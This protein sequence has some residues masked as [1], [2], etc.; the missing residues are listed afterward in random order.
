MLFCRRILTV[1]FTLGLLLLGSPGD[2]AKV[3]VWQQN[4]QSHFDKARFQQALVTSEGTIRLS[5]QV[6]LLADLNALNL[7]DVI[8][9]KAGNLYAATGD[10]GK[11]W[12]V[13]PDGTAKVVYTSGD[14]QILCLAQGPNGVLFAGTG[15]SG[16]IVRIASEGAQVLADGLDSYVWALVFDPESKN[17]F[18]GTGSKGR[19]YRIGDDG[20]AQVYFQ[21]KQEH[22]LCLAGDGKGTLYA[23]TDKGGL[24]YRI[25]PPAAPDQKKGTGF[26]LYHTHQNEVRSLL[27]TDKAIYAGTSTPTRRPG[28]N[29]KTTTTMLPLGDG[30][31]ASDAPSLLA[32]GAPAPSTPPVGDNSIYRIALDGTAREIFHD[33]VMILRLLQDKGK[34]LAATGMNGQL[35]E[36]DENTREKSEIARLD[37][38]QIHCLL[39]RPDGSI[40]LGTGD[41][42]KLYVL[43]NHFAATGTVTSEVLDAKIIS[44]WGALNWR[45]TTPPETSA[46]VA[47]RS[48]NVSEAD[49]TWSAWS[50]EQTNPQ[51]ARALAPLARYIQYRVT[52]NSKQPQTTPEFRQFVLRYK[53][54]NQAPEI[55]SL[56]VP[57]LESGTV[58]NPRKLKIRWT[59]TDPNEDELTYRLS[60][61]KEGWKDWVLLE[62]DFEKKEFEWDT[63]TVPSGSYRFKVVASDRR[64]NSPEETLTA[65][66]TSASFPVAHAAPSV[67]IRVTGFDGGKAVIE[68]VATDPLVRLTE[69][70]FA[71][72]GKHWANIFPADGLFDSKSETFRFKTEELRPGS[73]VLMLRVKN[74]A[75]NVGSGDVLF[76]VPERK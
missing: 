42:G 49:D 44:K 19:I 21:T 62:D 74:A 8:A 28:L 53:T 57:D 23:G 31:L 3:K 43:E 47:V 2:A 6:K 30:D 7:W 45:A 58:D 9:D 75:G 13:A 65:E 60:F 25:S 22:I 55:T 16:K 48:G 33:K 38:G 61:K 12:K 64:D 76:T 4:L 71:V 52:L 70:S 37:H 63:T 59:A 18:A 51:D 39:K 73:H 1:S 67:T 66:R 36:I 14:S 24:V 29:G 17:L 40:I 26:V 10:Q 69:A 46:S 54:T 20:K 34:L 11:L 41:P 56:E 50:A 68:A 15:P 5:R 27:V 72:S 32:Q 35:F